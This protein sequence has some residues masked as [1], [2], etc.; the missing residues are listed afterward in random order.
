MFGYWESLM[1]EQFLKL[2]YSSLLR[3]IS[4]CLFFSDARIPGVFFRFLPVR[5]HW[6]RQEIGGSFHERTRSSVIPF[7]SRVPLGDIVPKVDWNTPKYHYLYCNGWWIGVRKIAGSN[8]GVIRDVR[9]VTGGWTGQCLFVILSENY[10][11]IPGLFVFPVRINEGIRFLG[12][13]RTSI[14]ISYRPMMFRWK[15]W[16]GTRCLKCWSVPERR[17]GWCQ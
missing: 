9:L 14:R 3:G 15:L 8:L 17:A 7:L 10:L 11:C 5:D 2:F 6:D 13:R 4:P 1:R 12:R 16:G